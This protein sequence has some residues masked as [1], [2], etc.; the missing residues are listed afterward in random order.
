MVG[1]SPVKVLHVVH[2]YFPESFGGVESYA[3]ALLPAQRQA[4]IDVLL[5]SGSMQPW[6]QCGLERL[7]AD[8]VPLYRLHRDDHY[9]DH[10]AKA[11]H[12]GVE[13]LVRDLL[14]RERPDLVHVHHWIRLTISLVEV[15]EDLG[16]PTVLTLH[17]VSA[18]CPRAFRVDRDGHSCSRA[19][20]VAHCVPCA[21][22]YG[23]E[24]DAEL[25][26][27]IELFGAS[28][29]SEIL[30]A[31]MVL[32][33]DASTADLVRNQLDI[34]AERFVALPLPYARRFAGTPIARTARAGRPL[35]IGYFG[36]VARHKGVPVLVEA[37]ASLCAQGL[38]APAE[39]HVYGRAETDALDAELRARAAGWPIVFHGRYDTHEL[40]AAD[41]DLAAFPSLA[42]ETF[43][44]VLDEAFE[45]GLPVMVADLGALTSRASGAALRVPPGDVA[46]W[47]RALA[48]VI[49]RPTQLDALRQ[50]VPP[51]APPLEQHVAALSAIYDQSRAAPP[52][53]TAPRVDWRRRAAFL[54]R[55]REAAQR[56]AGIGGPS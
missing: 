26:E 43:S 19:F 39:L 9:F 30:R 10:H 13:A 8:G 45:L 5:L 35:R 48:D 28:T 17:D 44:F 20:G 16:I 55:Q 34:P 46:A 53:A 33:N 12:P 25:R 41:L 22:R 2:G 38:P 52:Q 40:A 1:A 15:A 29:R 24:S 32:V 3:R 27:G 36:N 4:G 14:L 54:L 6:E 23:F 18:T 56:R 50:R 51:P 21:P 7:E 49:A 11:W 47:Q 37:F 31:R 42:F